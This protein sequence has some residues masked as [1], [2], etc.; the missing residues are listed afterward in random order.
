M[1]RTADLEID[2]ARHVLEV[3]AQPMAQFIA[4]QGG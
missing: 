3:I 1:M 2:Q 4:L